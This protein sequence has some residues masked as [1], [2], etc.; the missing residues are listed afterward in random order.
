M[1]TTLHVCKGT[2]TETLFNDF[3]TL[4]KLN[5][6]QFCRLTD[7]VLQ[8]LTSKQQSQLLDKLEAYCNEESLNLAG[9]KNIIKSFLFVP[10]EAIKKGISVAQL[11]EDLQKL[12]LNEDKID[13][14]ANK[15]NK[16][17]SEI[18]KMH[19]NEL[20]MVNRLVDMEWKF[21]VTAASSELNKVGNTFLQLKLVIDQGNN[22]L[23]NVYLELS[24][25]QFYSFLHEME[26]ARA[27]LEYLS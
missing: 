19:L 14:L 21:G 6:D 10:K 17:Y 11:R 4:N 18:A 2:P 27:S 16:D 26:R 15:W 23:Q 7:I 24:L 8:F 3:Q 20:V 13:Y 1:A 5:K 22:R 9:L 12:G 25:S